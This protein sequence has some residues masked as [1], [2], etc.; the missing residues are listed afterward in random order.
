VELKM[1][2]ILRKLEG[3]DRRTIGRVDDVIN[4]VLAD[5]QLFDDLVDGMFVENPVVRMRAADALEKISSN[6]PELLQPHKKT[7]LRLAA[8]I[9]QQEVRWHIAQ[10][11]SR[12]QLTPGEMHAIADILF[13][14]L[15]DK[16][17]I[18][19][20]FS[21]QALADLAIEDNS[22]KA[23]VLKVL[24]KLTQTGSPAVKNRGKKLLSK[25]TDGR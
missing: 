1:N 14:Y 8:R 18:V 12:L 23:R 13:S 9:E 5:T 10:M 20:T 2:A 15:D 24:E 22:L 25:L 7:I 16:S 17:N 3:G 11:I 19:V 21:L 6:Y 4:D